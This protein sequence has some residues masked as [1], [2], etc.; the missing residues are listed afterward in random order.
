MNMQEHAVTENRQLATFR[1]G[2]EL[3][4]LGISSIREIV[5]YPAITG[6]PRSPAYLIGLANMRGNV[7][8]VVDARLR[9]GVKV[10]PITDMT[11]V[12]V[13]EIGGTATG[14]VVDRVCGVISLESASV[15]S[16]PELLNSGVDTK[17]VKSVLK[18]DGGKKIIMEINAEN[19]CL[20]EAAVAQVARQEASR[21]DGRRTEVIEA[22]EPELQLVTFLVAREE[23]AFPIESV[24]E[25]LRIGA[26]TEVPD[27]PP[28]ILGILAV[29][30]A[31]LP[32]VDVRRLLGL[33]SLAESLHHEL[34]EVARY[35]E[36]LGHAFAR[37]CATPVGAWSADAT[38]GAV[39]RWLDSLHTASDLLGRQYQA[40]RGLF[41]RLLATVRIDQRTTASIDQRAKGVA[42]FIQ[43]KLD[44]VVG[45]TEQVRLKVTECQKILTQEIPEDQRILVIEIGAMPVGIL[46]D[47]MHQVI[48]LPEKSIDTPPP[49]LNS[50]KASSLKGIVKL[51][52]GKRL[53]MLV[54]QDT[55]LHGP[56]I[57]ALYTASCGCGE[58]GG[59]HDP[60]DLDDGTSGDT[61]QLVTF[62]LGDEEYGIPIEE[63]QEINRFE[64]ITSV[65]RA[66]AFVEG[67]MN[68]RGNVI[69]AIDL[70]KRFGLET[71]SHDES[72]RVIIV[73][74]NGKLTG[75]IVDAVSEVFR[76]QQ[77]AI[78]T[79][80][81]VICSERG[82]EFVKGICKTTHPE[83]KMIVLLE[84][85][86]LLAI[87]EQQALDGITDMHKSE[88]TSANIP[89][90]MPTPSVSAQAVS[91]PFRRSEPEQTVPAPEQV[92][93]EQVSP[94]QVSPEQ[95]LPEPV[96]PAPV[97]PA[98]VVPEPVVPEPVIVAEAF[99]APEPVA[100]E[101]VPVAEPALA[102]SA[103]T[104]P[105]PSPLAGGALSGKKLKRAQ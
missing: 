94:E 15:E 10:S 18:A 22:M 70:R 86:R 12:L 103:P 75:L 44:N 39:T 33:P 7:L 93:P 16:P 40:L 68:L 79:P 96:A 76:L 6:V 1:I 67:V 105:A 28:H 31:L 84:V 41:V 24:R 102:E 100:P 56:D 99:I 29:R 81:C 48:R 63:V 20:T 55:M 23:Y 98:P 38:S 92:S 9:L 59:R 5:R 19:L 34:D 101:P 2:D 21:K 91:A 43:E 61:V 11:R 80:P 32:V 78:E 54:D 30:N 50:E 37:H 42:G 8:P 52:N 46:V 88:Q 47:R 77:Q 26:I 27:E 3:F 14:L 17:Y 87:H 72:T 95:A 64:E 45:L 97:A 89:A 82:M 58:Y 90:V 51:D 60:L 74:M 73:T 4:G 53:I 71:I 85:S 13:I 57:A 104:E 35:A 66:P 69:P 49:L 65:P 62:R 25:V 83:R 36:H